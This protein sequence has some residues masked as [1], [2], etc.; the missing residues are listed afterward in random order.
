MLNI[1]VPQNILKNGIRKFILPTST[2][3]P[4]NNILKISAVAKI[5]TFESTLIL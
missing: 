1:G 2:S 4:S 5:S 3:L